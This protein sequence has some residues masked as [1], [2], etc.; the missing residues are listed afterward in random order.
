MVIRDT[1]KTGV[2][3]LLKYKLLHI[4]DFTSERKRMSVIVQ[5][6]NSVERPILLLTKG[7]D[8]IIIPRTINAAHSE[9]KTNLQ[10]ALT[11]YAKSGL[12][13]LVLAQKEIDPDYYHYWDEKYVEALAII[14]PEREEA[15]DN[16]Q[17][18]LEKDLSIVA[19]TAIEDKLQQEVKETIED[20][21]KSNIKV[22]M[23]TGDKKETA[24]SIG[25]SCGLI[26]S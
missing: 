15:V 21:K 22:W 11:A 20:L 25:Y 10:E 1:S 23:L 3:K 12:R 18:E 5:D 2:T 4:L 13:T 8:E 6:L 19:A 7:A 14:G 26:S 17:S 9:E 16:M 24:V